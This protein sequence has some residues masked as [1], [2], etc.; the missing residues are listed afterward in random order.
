[1][2]GKVGGTGSLG[3]LSLGGSLAGLG[4]ELGGEE[5]GTTLPIPYEQCIVFVNNF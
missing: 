3:L 2:R 1:M 4:G 5:G